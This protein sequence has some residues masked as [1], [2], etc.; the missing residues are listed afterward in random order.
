MRRHTWG[1]KKMISITIDGNPI[2]WKRAG[3]KV[4]GG[5]VIHYDRQKKEKEQIRW[6]LRD[7]YRSEM[8]TIPCMIDLTFYKQ[9]PKS[10]SKKMRE[11]MLCDFVKCSGRPDLDN[12]EKF[13]FDAMT[14]VVIKDDCLFVEK[15]SRK[16]W[17]LRPAT[18]IRI[19]PF[20]ENKIEPPKED[21]LPLEDYLEDDL[22]V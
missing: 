4:I 7:V 20:I 15:H 21:D 12:Y 14:G 11:Q 16:V 5:R 18:L 13:I 22:Y 1:D 17:S 10:A 19:A 3:D 6:Q 8:L 2:P 9:I